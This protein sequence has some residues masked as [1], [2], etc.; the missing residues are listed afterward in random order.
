[1]EFLYRGAVQGATVG[2][3]DIDKLQAAL[4]AAEF[5]HVDTL[6]QDAHDWAAICGVEIHTGTSLDKT[7][8]KKETGVHNQAQFCKFEHEYPFWCGD[9]ETSVPAL[10]AHIH[11]HELQRAVN[12][13][14]STRFELSSCSAQLLC[15][16]DESSCE[17]SF[18]N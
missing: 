4:L 14:V 10:L 5:F 6:A 11:H 13:H 17:R 8:S 18:S 9:E 2:R 15:F 16:R 1:M 12:F 3:V 7:Q